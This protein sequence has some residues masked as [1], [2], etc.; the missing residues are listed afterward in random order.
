[1]RRIFLALLLTMSVFGIGHPTISRADLTVGVSP[2]LIEL[3][4]KAN[5]TGSVDLTVLNQGDVPFD[6]TISSEIYSRAV[7][8]SKPDWLVPGVT[9]AHL[10]AASQTVVPVSIVIPKDVKPGG[11][12]AVIAILTG[13]PDG[14]GNSAGISGQLSVPFLITVEGKYKRKAEVT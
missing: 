9:A 7:D 5:S 8:R 10:E 6:V 1:M 12:Y 3:S 4:G 14:S 2:S 11:Y 13:A